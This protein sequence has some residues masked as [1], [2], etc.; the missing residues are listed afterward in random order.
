MNTFTILTN[1][2]RISTPFVIPTI[3]N[4]LIKPELLNHHKKRRQNE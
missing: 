2:V 4:L 3:D 1:A